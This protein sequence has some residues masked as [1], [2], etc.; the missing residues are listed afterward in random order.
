VEGTLEEARAKRWGY[1]GRKI[2][3]FDRVS[4]WIDDVG[5]ALLWPRAKTAAP[6][7]W[8]IGS[9]DASVEWGPDAE[10]MWRWKDELPK[11]RRAWYGHYLFGRKSFLSLQLLPHLYPREGTADDY[12]AAGLSKDAMRVAD[13]IFASGPTSSAALREATN[14]EG[15]Q[16]SKAVAELGRA[17]VVTHFGVEEQGAGWP[18]A[19]LELTSRVF[20]LKPSQDRARAARTFLGTVIEC[21]PNDLARAFNWSAPDARAILDE[22]VATNAATNDKSVYTAA[23]PLRRR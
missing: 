16:Y 19:V 11:R 18:S 7:L 12:K 15:A 21:K 10:R 22:L 14:L 1:T 9:E 13:V 17:L 20:K 8:A 3:S 2:V 4:E 6:V 5:F 23:G